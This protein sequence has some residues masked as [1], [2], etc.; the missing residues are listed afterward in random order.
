V[1]L[2]QL[3]IR[4][5]KMYQSKLKGNLFLVLKNFKKD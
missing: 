2:R 5:L 4:A 3:I 1:D